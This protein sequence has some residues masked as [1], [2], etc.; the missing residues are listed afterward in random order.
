MKDYCL[1]FKHLHICVTVRGAPYSRYTV[2][3]RRLLGKTKTCGCYAA[4]IVA[5]IVVLRIGVGWHFLY[6]GLW[7]ANPA[8]DFSSKGFLGMAKG[9]TKDFYYFFLPDLGGEERIQ[10]A[11]V[12]RVALENGQNTAQQ[13]IGWTFPVIE[14]EWFK[15]FDDYR[16]HFQLNDDE[17][18]AQAKAIFDQYVLSLREYVLENREDIRGFVASKA[19]FEDRLAKTKND[20]EYQ[21]IRNWD[22]QTKYRSEGEKFASA[23]VKM[24]ENMQ[25]DLWNILTP[26][27]KEFG[28]LPAITYGQD[29]CALMQFVATLPWI[30]DFAKGSTMGA[31]DAMVTVGLT[32]IGLCLILGLCTRL[33]ALGGACFLIN[34]VLSQFPW[35]TVYPYSPDMVG[36]FMIF[37][38]DGIELLIL[39]LI[40]ALPAGRWGGLDWFLWN[41]VGKNL[42]RWYG[43]ESDPLSPPCHSAEN[44]A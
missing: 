37:N 32:A 11:E 15:Y 12:Y 20:A 38:K 39:L 26:N 34:V 35:P 4:L 1:K 29:K 36:H 10:M 27:Q 28:E 43:I 42:Y 7:K 41:L 3:R 14:K 31:L 23:P 30:S 16:A 24:G 19:R 22:A 33:A 2:E 13:R 40:A 18:L 44:C 25:L 5:L 6:E 17:Q 9:P 21:R 8:N